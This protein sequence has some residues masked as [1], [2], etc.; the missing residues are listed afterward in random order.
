MGFITGVL[1]LYMDEEE[2]FWMLCALMLSERFCMRAFYQD[3]MPLLTQMFY[4]LEHLIDHYCPKLSKHM[5]GFLAPLVLH[6][7]MLRVLASG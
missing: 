6:P 5:V 1:L 7:L 2:A 4:Q 3:G